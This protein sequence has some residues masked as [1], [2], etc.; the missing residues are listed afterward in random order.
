[1]FFLTRPSHLNPGASPQKPTVRRP[2]TTS[3]R[4]P[5]VPCP[6]TTCWPWSPYSPKCPCTLKRT[7]STL[8]CTVCTPSTGV[9]LNRCPIC[10]TFLVPS[11]WL[12]SWRSMMECRR[13]RVWIGKEKY[14]YLYSIIYLYL[15]NSFLL[16]LFLPSTFY[17]FPTRVDIEYISS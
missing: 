1:M 17:T 7:G 6:T 5:S 8:G 13:W 9:T 16:I 3:S 2:R 4:M 14:S 12:S 11:W 10:F 15:H